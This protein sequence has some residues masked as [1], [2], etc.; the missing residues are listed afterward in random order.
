MC[1]PGSVSKRDSPAMARPRWTALY[2]I[3]TSSVAALALTEIAADAFVRPALESV[4]GAAALVAIALW[5]R[6]NRAALDQQDW[7]ECAAD[8]LTVRVIPSRRPEKANSRSK[9]YDHVDGRNELDLARLVVVW[10]GVGG[11]VDAELGPDDHA[12]ERLVGDAE[13]HVEEAR[14]ETRTSELAR[15]GALLVAEPLDPRP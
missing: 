1:A 11:P 14:G 7:C 13:G 4:V 8:T 15:S 9:S 6:G 3:A 5:L 12:A 10:P 2:G